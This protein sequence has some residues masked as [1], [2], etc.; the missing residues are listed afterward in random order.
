MSFSPPAIGRRA[1]LALA[2]GVTLAGQAGKVQAQ[3]RSS[4]HIVIIGAGAAGLAMA[5]RLSRRLD[6]ARITIL[7]RQSRH[8]YQPGLTMVGSGV[9]APSKV[10]STNAQWM[11]A[12]VDWVREAAAEIDPAGNHVVTEG[13]RR[14]RYDFL[15]VAAGLELNYGGI[16]GL[17]EELIGREGIGNIYGG[18]EAALATWRE[19]AR[20]AERGGIVVHGRPASE[21]KCAGAP[22]KLAFLSH[23]RFTDAGTR[24]RS[25]FI[26]NAHNQGTFAVPEIHRRVVELFA[27]RDIRINYSHVLRAV[28]PGRRI[29]TYRTPN[30][31]VEQ[32]YDFLHAV[33]PQRTP[34]AIRNSPLPWQAGPLA[35]DGWVEA[36]RGTLRHPRFPNV[37]TVGDA[38]GV[39]RGKTAATV[40]K[41]VPIATDNLMAVIAGREPQPLF[42]GYTSCPL[43]TDIGR[44]MLVEFDYDAKLVPSFPFVDPLRDSWFG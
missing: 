27:E 34:P 26:Y 29:A 39:P 41:M 19:M 22:V 32:R 2:A 9:W 20:V 25:E 3:Q 28:D 6:G 14:I 17:S 12:G 8:V 30:G 42:N 21:M 44:A 18:P 11:P 43:I 24:G 33:P 40:K 35:A 10:I 1:T 16:E 13:G 36:D 7:D 15:V 23:R 5:S 38:T 4:A 31:D 37:F